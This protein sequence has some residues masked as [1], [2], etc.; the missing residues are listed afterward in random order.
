MLIRNWNWNERFLFRS[1]T[2]DRWNRFF[3]VAT[4][5]LILNSSN[6]SSNWIW[7]PNQS[8]SFRNPITIQLN[9]HVKSS[10]G[11]SLHSSLSLTR[12]P[13]RHFTNKAIT[14]TAPIDNKYSPLKS[15]SI[16]VSDLRQFSVSKRDFLICIKAVEWDIRVTHEM[17]NAPHDGN[18]CSSNKN[19][20]SFSLFLTLRAHCRMSKP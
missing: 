9:S 15:S 4:I 6:L 18:R 1:A 14:L 20:Y 16:T 13:R 11:I 7:N 3:E 10:F 17:P 5:N 19:F 12:F 2:W 8:L